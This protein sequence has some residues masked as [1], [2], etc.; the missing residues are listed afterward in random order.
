MGLA[1]RRAAKEFEDTQFPALKDEIMKLAGGPIALEINWNQLAAMILNGG[2]PVAAGDA[3]GHL[4]VAHALIGHLRAFGYNASKGRIVLP[5]DV[6][7]TCG[8]VEADIRAGRASEN[9]SVA[10]TRF[11]DLASDHLRRADTAIDALPRD[12][13][14]A[15]ATTALLQY[16]CS[17]A[18]NCPVSYITTWS[19]GLKRLTKAASQA[20]VPEEG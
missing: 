18:A 14:S 8:V 19:P 10:L 17:S 13:R 1:E 6:F 11:A 16:T 20:P 7:A 3:A 4:G 12:L 15:F 9:L 2:R 5:R